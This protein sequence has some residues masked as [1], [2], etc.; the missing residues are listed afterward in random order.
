MPVTNRGRALTLI[1][2]LVSIA[3]I[4]IVLG[5]LMPALGRA[6]E[7]GRGASCAASLHQAG[8]A[9]TCYLD[10]N[11]GIFFPYYQDIP[12]AGGGRRWWF[13]FEKGGPPANAY[14]KNRPLDKA[15][16][17]LGR[18]MSGSA[19]AFLCPSFPFDAGGYS[20][21]FSS[22][23]GGYGYN[24]EALA[25]YGSPNGGT[26]RSRKITEFAGRTSDVFILADGIHFDR[27]TMSGSTATGPFNEP[28]YIQ[29]Q[30]PEVFCT[31]AGVNGGFAHFRHSNRAVAL[32]LDG[33]AGA[34]TARRPAHPYRSLG[35]VSNLADEQDRTRQ[36]QRGTTTAKIDIIYG[37]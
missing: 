37:L 35:P 7:G 3:I 29:W 24:A 15:A 31:S 9:T 17:F 12:G 4:A 18:Y 5:I 21:K 8:I 30:R 34:Q 11:D 32:Y 27:L 10:E 25:G 13:G 1:E 16:G 6:R 2:L 19:E 23:A 20:R 22:P 33:H 26:I 36:V 14:A 28:P